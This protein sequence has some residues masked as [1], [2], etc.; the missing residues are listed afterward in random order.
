MSQDYQLTE[1][2]WD[3]LL[4]R[5]NDGK[6]TPFLGAGVNSGTLPLVGEIAR[7]WAQRY[8]YPLQDSSDLARVA[9]YLAVEYDPMFPKEQFLKEFIIDA[10]PPDFS[11]DNEP[12]SVLAD[13]PIPIYI[14]TFAQID[15]QMKD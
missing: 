4:T 6:C 14:S 9:Q 2:D 3:V 7:I 13:L 12:H 1:R 10:V 15:E 11:Q 5:I 8:G